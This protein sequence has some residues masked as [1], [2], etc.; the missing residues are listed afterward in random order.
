MSI[1][2]RHSPVRDVIFI[3]IANTKPRSPL[4]DAIFIGRANT[5]PSSP[6]RDVI[7]IGECQLRKDI[8]PLGT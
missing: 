5:K 8:V 3:G 7:F 6:V 2:Q 4:R 1:A